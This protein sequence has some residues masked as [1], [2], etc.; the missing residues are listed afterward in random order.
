MNAPMP[1]AVHTDW[2]LAFLEQIAQSD[3][4]S[5]HVVLWDGAGFHPADGAEGVP[6]NVR[7]IRLPPYSPELNPA[8]KAGARLRRALANRLPKGLDELDRWATEALRPLWEDPAEVR[9]LI[10]RGWLPLQV[11]ASSKIESSRI[12]LSLVLPA[13]R[14]DRSQRPR[15]DQGAA[16]G[17]CRGL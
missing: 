6:A 1:T 14:R 2:S 4:A 12:Q 7:L 5:I 11:N 13:R 16:A 17:V 8:E 15:R 10:G 9:S 3:P